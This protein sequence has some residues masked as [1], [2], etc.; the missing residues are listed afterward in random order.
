MR[1]FLTAAFPNNFNF[2]SGNFE[3]FGI[4]ADSTSVQG[5]HRRLIC[6]YF[7]PPSHYCNHFKQ[8]IAKKQLFFQNGN[9]EPFQFLDDYFP[10]KISIITI[11][12]I[13]NQLYRCEIVHIDICPKTAN[14]NYGVF[15]IQ[16]VIDLL[17]SRFYWRLKV[18]YLAKHC[19][20]SL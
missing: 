7:W 3:R 11:L 8:K 9:G 20:F 16:I 5:H 2:I 12:K 14:Q 10:R 18:I 13:N 6:N 15:L 1:I 17:R 19:N 4:Y